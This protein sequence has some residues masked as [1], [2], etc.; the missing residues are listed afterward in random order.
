MMSNHLSHP[1]S[2]SLIRALLTLPI[3]VFTGSALLA[4]LSAIVTL[5]VF[6]RVFFPTQ[7]GGVKCGESSNKPE[8]STTDS[9]S[10]QTDF[11]NP[12][13]AGSTWEHGHSAFAFSNPGARSRV[14]GLH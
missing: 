4:R 8:P 10:D 6:G 13:Q 2:H 12:R 5:D 14:K 3:L 7:L 11:P 9:A 1:M